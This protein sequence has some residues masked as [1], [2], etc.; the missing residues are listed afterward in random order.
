[1][2]PQFCFSSR[3]RSL[4]NLSP[5][6]EIL[7]IRISRYEILKTKNDKVDVISIISLTSCFV[8]VY[9]KWITF[10]S[11]CSIQHDIRPCFTRGTSSF[12]KGQTRYYWLMIFSF[13]YKSIWNYWWN[14]NVTVIS[15]RFY[16]NKSINDWKMCRKLLCLSMEVVGSKITLPK[17]CIPTMA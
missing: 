6:I 7:K 5:K 10:P 3:G 9:C 14:L 1:M 17:S 2:D 8:S 11:R 12:K 15:R 16:L 4:S 13:L